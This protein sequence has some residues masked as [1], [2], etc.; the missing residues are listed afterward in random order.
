MNILKS[1]EIQFFSLTNNVIR[2][3]RLVR[4]IDSIFY[5]HI[6]SEKYVHN[7]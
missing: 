4:Q 1:D 2:A 7:L 6:H 5:L 3:D